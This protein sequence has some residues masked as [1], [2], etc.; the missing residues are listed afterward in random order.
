MT[1]QLAKI[2]T[3]SRDDGSTAAGP[4]HDRLVRII[5]I[6]DLH[7]QSV[8]YP[9]VVAQHDGHAIAT[10]TL[11]GLAARTRPTAA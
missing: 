11:R 10:N 1:D 8:L 4:Y 3:S 6:Q 9:I 7:L 5:W 2:A